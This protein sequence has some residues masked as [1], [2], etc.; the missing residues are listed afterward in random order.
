MNE[1]NT[2]GRFFGRQEP[3]N[4]PLPKTFKPYTKIMI[5]PAGKYRV[6]AGLKK[7]GTGKV[8]LLHNGEEEEKLFIMGT[9]WREVAQ[10][11]RLLQGIVIKQE[12]ERI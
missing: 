10:E 12:R 3:R 9:D 1:I 11:A 4:F 5:I 2:L 8:A 6:W 7:S